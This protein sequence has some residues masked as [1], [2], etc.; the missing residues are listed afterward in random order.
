[1]RIIIFGGFLGSGKT[2]ILMQIAQFLVENSAGVKNNKIVILENEIGQ[3]GVDDMLLKSNGYTVSELFAGCACCTM[4]GE[5]RGNVKVIMREMNPEWLIV[6]ATGIACPMN[7]KD[8]LDPLVKCP[9]I[10]VSVVDASRFL[11]MLVPLNDLLVSQLKD[12]SYIFVNKVDLV[13]EETLQAVKKS[14]NEMAPGARV[15]PVRGLL[16]IDGKVLEELTELL[17]RG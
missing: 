15:Q 11:R 14:V 3:V 4:S 10:I 2:T 6:E 13:S 5:L 16:P 1:M 8:V 17:I 12:A 9:A 7:I